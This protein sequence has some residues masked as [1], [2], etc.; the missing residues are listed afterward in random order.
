MHEAL[1]YDRITEGRVHCRLCSH[2]CIIT[3][4]ARGLCNVRRNDGGTLVSLVYERV[5]AQSVDP[6][7]KKPLFHFYPGT[8]SYSIATVGCNFTC[9]HCQNN[10]I[11]QYPRVHAGQIVGDCVPALE[12]VEKAVE[13]GCH[14]IAYTYTEPTI[15][16]EYVLD[17]M[18]LA[19]EAGL[20]NV[21][22][23]NGYFTAEAAALLV[24]LLDAANIDLKGIS[25]EMYHEIIGGTV[26]PV[27]NSIERLARAGVWVEVTTLV[28]PGVN[29]SDD[30]LRWT[31]EAI[32]GISPAIPWHVSR[33]FP[34]HQMADR[35]PTPIETLRKAR[36]T[37]LDVGLQFVYVGNLPGESESTQ[38]PTCG[39]TVIE[40]SGFLAK[41]VRLDEGICPECKTAIPGRWFTADS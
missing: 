18:K 38:C 37:G 11:S 31:A 1:L 20:T 14:S 29:D 6:I 32:R 7:E 41:H 10:H 28:I 27:L 19:R 30:E 12:I 2:C 24:P 21:W 4:G 16:I 9:L 26:R 3:D 13:S 33:F 17:V 39:T 23:T 35:D 36:N 40:R 34:S 15:A 5:V 25:D 8:R 22:V